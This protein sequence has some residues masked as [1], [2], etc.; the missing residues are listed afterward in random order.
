MAHLVKTVWI[1]FLISPFMP[2][3]TPLLAIY[4]T[5]R[6]DKYS[7]LR[8]YKDPPQFSYDLVLAILGYLESVILVHC[9]TTIVTYV[10]VVIQNNTEARERYM[11]TFAIVYSVLYIIFAL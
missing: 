6:I 7:L 9:W 11:F 3:V 8:Y 2:L 1:G 5:L 10:I 4:F